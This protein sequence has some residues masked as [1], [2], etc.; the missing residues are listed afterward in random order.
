MKHC[1]TVSDKQLQENALYHLLIILFILFH[2]MRRRERL[3]GR[4][5]E[6]LTQE[7]KQEKEGRF[8]RRRKK[9]GQR[10][11][12][13]TNMER[14]QTEYDRKIRRR[15]D[16]SQMIEPLGKVFLRWKSDLIP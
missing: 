13:K 2:I 6:C 11:L 8:T 15:I 16:D 9:S 10:N 1:E 7:K 5:D 14:I 12:R 3:H 4:R